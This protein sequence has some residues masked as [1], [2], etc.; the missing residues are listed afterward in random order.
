MTF[1][2]SV[3]LA[4]L[5]CLPLFCSATTCIG[6]KKFKV[7]QVCGQVRTVTGDEIPDAIIQ[8]TR[9][10][11]SSARARMQSDHEGNFSFGRLDGGEY[12]IRV[13]V[14]GFHTASQEFEIRRPIKHEQSCTHPLLVSMQ[15]A[16]GCSSVAKV[17]AKDVKKINAQTH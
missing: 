10:G 14:G 6:L 17:R 5:I 2:R 15:V 3:I 12:V 8:V 4:I 11:D 1:C 9:N 16:N 13:D 7:R